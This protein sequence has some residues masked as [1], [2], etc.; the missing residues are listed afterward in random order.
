MKKYLKFILKTSKIFWVELFSFSILINLIIGYLFNF[1]IHEILIQCIISILFLPAL[2]WMLG[3][4]NKIRLNIFERF[5][6]N[7]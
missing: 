4:F 1:S 3:G 2:V 5:N 6:L 7:D